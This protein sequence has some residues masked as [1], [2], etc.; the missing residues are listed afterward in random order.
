MRV[1]A[2]LT[3]IAALAAASA[4][5]I[6]GGASGAARSAASQAT[7][8]VPPSGSVLTGVSAGS[9]SAFAAQV[10][11]H[12][13]VFGAFV[14]WGHSIHWAFSGAA[15]AH[16]RLMLH[17]STTMGYG[18]PQAITPAAVA[19]GDGDGYLI[20][21]SHLISHYR[22]PVYVRLFPEMDQ[23]NNAYCGFNADGSSRGPDYAPSELVAAWRRV[24]TV[25]RGGA[26]GDIDA[27]LASLGQPHLHGL[28]TVAAISTPPV[29]FVW[30][31][32]VAGSPDIP[33]NSPAAY[34]PGDQYVDWVGTDFYSNF[35][36]FKGLEAFYREYPQKPFAFG[37]WAIWD[38][39]APAFVDQLFGWVGS[40][41]RVGMMLYNQGYV[42]NGPF[43]LNRDPQST[44]AIRQRLADSRFLGFTPEWQG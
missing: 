12:P 23:A 2:R 10:G 18:A 30:T 44:V 8:L 32:Q 29:S 43:R 24:V 39:D 9:A 38:G 6:A 31:P 36:N 37:E 26:V 20:E 3:L 33:A 4:L 16:A 15:A 42:T 35:P 14:T 34:Y 1:R 19:R 7:P 5:A 21:L 41:K 22:Q 25:L 13:A 40:H 28:P 17:V 11:K 27:Q